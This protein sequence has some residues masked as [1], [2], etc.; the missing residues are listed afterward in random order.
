MDLPQVVQ[1]LPDEI[2][3]HIGVC[4]GQRYFEFGFVSNQRRGECEHRYCFGNHIC[5]TDE[6]AAICRD[7]VL[8]QVSRVLSVINLP[9]PRANGVRVRA[10]CKS[11]CL[12]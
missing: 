2:G 1:Q 10:A 3:R 8:S 4:I 7:R 5:E 12:K 11:C 9:S 6:V